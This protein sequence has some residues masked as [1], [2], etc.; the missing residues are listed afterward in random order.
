M[1]C[2]GETKMEKKK[3][4]VHWSIA[5]AAIGATL[6]AVVLAY[7]MGVRV[8]L[9]P[10]SD[11]AEGSVVEVSRVS[12]DATHCWL[13]TGVQMLKPIDC[14]SLGGRLEA[15]PRIAKPETQSPVGKV[16]GKSFASG[17][18]KT[19]VGWQPNGPTYFN[20]VTPSAGYAIPSSG[21]SRNRGG[22]S[23]PG[24]RSISENSSPRRSSGGVRSAS[25]G[26]R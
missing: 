1:R 15:P 24:S 17:G 18:G 9:E 14:L 10:A 25:G 6:G 21:S 23:S 2:C 16:S 20:Y 11:W 22:V 12:F 4:D 13:A 19:Q 26:M 5:A 3:G 8:T 7:L